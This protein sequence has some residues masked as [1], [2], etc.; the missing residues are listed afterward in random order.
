MR[1]E[2]PY[3]TIIGDRRQKRA[4][5]IAR[6]LKDHFETPVNVRRT[7]DTFLQEV[8][9]QC[10]HGIDL[11][12]LSEGLPGM[13]PLGKAITELREKYI[14]EGNV[15]V[16]LENPEYTLHPPG[17]VRALITPKGVVQSEQARDLIGECLT[18]SARELVLVLPEKPPDYILVEQVRSLDPRGS[19]EAAR[20]I[21]RRLI[22]NVRGNCIQARIQRLIQGFSGA[23][24]FRIDLVFEE[25]DAKCDSFM[26]KVIPEW[27][28]KKSKNEVDHWHDIQKTLHHPLRGHVPLPVRPQEPCKES[29]LLV[30]SDGFFAVAFQFLGGELGKFTDL[31]EAYRRR[32][33]CYPDTNE[34]L[35]EFLVR[36]VIRCLDRAWYQ[37]ARIEERV[38]WSE[39]ASI[40]DE[41][42][43]PP[44]YKLTSRQK[45]RVLQ[46][47]EGYQ[48]LG[49]RLLGD[50]WHFAAEKVA[51]WVGGS[52]SGYNIPALR[53]AVTLSKVHGDLNGHNIYLWEDVGQPILIDFASYQEEGH[54]LQ[55]FA[56]LEGE[57]KFALMDR[58]N[59]SSL[60]ALD[61]TPDQL[62][63]WRQ[64]E[65]HL[66]SPNWDAPVVLGGEQVTG[67]ERAVG[68]IQVVRRS[69]AASHAQAFKQVAGD[70]SFRDD[71]SFRIE[72]FVALLYHTLRAVGY[73]D[74][75]PFKRL[76]AVY[77]AARL[78]EVLDTVGTA[79]L[80]ISR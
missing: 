74:L 30:Q 22:L 66:I 13:G 3:V 69:A 2:A 47:L 29:R 27:S 77:S 64:A 16:L 38:L 40:E 73:E 62:E 18:R 51:A 44:P 4:Q 20:A 68:L 70:H 10:E 8:Q 53:H 49:P 5:C 26:I 43:V 24:V 21:L 60:G 79:S 36:Q 39:E 23:R 65:D 76:L 48:I 45:T 25:S 6:I 7:W 61:L 59:D 75:S 58:E 28:L 56:R 54:M 33:A 34:P 63:T 32:P 42:L 31:E 17:G 78:I 71:H 9:E 46:T 15:I 55:D 67:V 35:A 19:F 52:S 72:Y 37:K 80:P 57:V 50:A 41:V 14:H 12:L 11:V 1:S